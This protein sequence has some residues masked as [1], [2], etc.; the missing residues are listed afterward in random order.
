MADSKISE[1]T[2]AT[3]TNGSDLFII[4]QSGDNK[5][6][7]T[8]NFLANVQDPIVVNSTGNSTTTF[9]VQGDTDANLLKSSP[10][11]DRIGVGTASPTEKLDVNGNLAVSGGFIKLSQTPE[12]LNCTGTSITCSATTA[13]TNIQT[14]TTTCTV[15]L[16]DGVQGQEKTF[17]MTNMG[18]NNAILVP[19]NK[20]GY[21]SI[22]FN[23]NGDTAR[24]LFDS[25][26]WVILSTYGTTVA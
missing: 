14:N 5:K 19:T 23:S 6:L 8:A 1:L 25:T 22:T 15:T 4:V 26:K 10:S 2:A 16:P 21:T 13:I 24:L 3:S 9:T 12:A 20:V 7:S 17:V 18:T 11:N